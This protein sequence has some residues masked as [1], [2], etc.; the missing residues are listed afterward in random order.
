MQGAAPGDELEAEVDLSSRPARGRILALLTPSLDRREPPCAYASACGGCA[1]IHITPSARHAARGQ[2]IADTVL[3]VLPEGSTPEV[4][5][6]DAPSELGYRARARLALHGGAKAAVG[7]HRPG[8]KHVVDIPA[9]VV[10]APSIAPAL[11]LLR[12]AIRGAKGSGEAR[13]ATGAG[14]KLVLQISWKGELPANAFAVFERIVREGQAAGVSV[15]LDGARV[16]AVIGDVTVWAAGPDGEPLEAPGF[17]Q[18]N[19][20]VTAELTEHL[21]AIASPK[22]R[23]VVELY[24]GAG[25]FTVALAREATKY[26]AIESDA[27]AVAASR[28][29][30]ERRGITNVQLSAQD[31]ASAKLPRATSL[32]VLD[33]PRAGAL[34]VLPAIAATRAEDVVYISCD[35]ATLG[36][37]IKK[38]EEAGF[39][40]RS[41]HTFDMFP[42]TSHVETVAH[43]V[44][45]RRG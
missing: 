14:G 35:P 31:A 23:E 26:T 28:R 43:L 37:D 1:W 40:L 21:R 5:H 34:P 20:A 9:C 13:V 45:P 38:L 16:P 6:H 8:A 22:D 7:F 18:A 15:A 41:L 4:V 32:V 24:A 19:P 2:L 17:S 30:L 33:P 39:S 25:T 3:R 12:E 42:Q 11:S 44:R 27:P 10:L 29:N 36:R